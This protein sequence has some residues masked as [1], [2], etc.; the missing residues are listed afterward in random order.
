MLTVEKGQGEDLPGYAE[1]KMAAIRAE[2][3]AVLSSNWGCEF[4]TRPAHPLGM[5][6][7]QTLEAY[8]HNPGTL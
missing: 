1:D 7:D 6:P 5:L 2:V 8:R 4:S 3:G